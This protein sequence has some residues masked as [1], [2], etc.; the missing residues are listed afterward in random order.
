M[1]LEE[2]KAI[3]TPNHSSIEKPHLEVSKIDNGYELSYGRM[4]EAPTLNFSTL[5]KLSELFGTDN[6]DVDNYGQGGCETCDYGSD[7]G[8]TIQIREIT[9]NADELK[10][11]VGKGDLYEKKK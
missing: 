6:V 11:L 8:H 4:Y 10:K 9:K 5:K 3:L 1:L 2:I 7:Y